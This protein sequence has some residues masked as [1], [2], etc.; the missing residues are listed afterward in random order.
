MYCNDSHE[1]MKILNYTSYLELR[2]FSNII[3]YLFLFVL[4]G[5]TS[6]RQT[7]TFLE[8]FRISL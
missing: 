3:Y 2:V 4:F 1:F 5:S 8:T 7:A 6:H